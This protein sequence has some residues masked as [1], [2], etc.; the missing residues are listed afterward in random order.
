MGSEVER[1]KGIPVAGDESDIKSLESDYRSLQQE[2][3]SLLAE[4]VRLENEL[5]NVKKKAS[6]LDE[7][8]RILKSPPL[9][10]GHLQDCLL[11]TSDAA[12]DP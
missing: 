6:R 4:R 12:D 11:Y 9:I 10:V 8:V 1:T 5:S 7:E 3:Q 2:A